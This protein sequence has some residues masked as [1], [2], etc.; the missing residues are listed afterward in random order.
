MLD[1]P[2]R[3]FKTETFSQYAKGG[4]KGY[5]VRDERYRLVQWTKGDEIVYELYDHVADP[6]E[7]K[8]IASDRSMKSVLESLNSKIEARKKEDVKLK[9]YLIRQ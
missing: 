1:Y 9:D 3:K 8:N 6:G 5:T 7:N 4:Y 2:D